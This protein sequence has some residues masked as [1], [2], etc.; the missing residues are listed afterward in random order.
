MFARV[1]VACLEQYTTHHCGG[2]TKWT[3]L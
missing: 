1:F 3:R 2:W